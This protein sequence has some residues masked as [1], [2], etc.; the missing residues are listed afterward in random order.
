MTTESPLSGTLSSQEMYISAAQSVPLK[1]I[2][3]PRGWFAVNWRELWAYRELLYFLTW[4]DIKVR[5]KQ[6]ALGVIW[7]LLQPF[8][9][10]IVFSVIFG[11]L[12]K[13]DSEGFPY[14]VFLYAGLLPWQ[15]FSEALSQSSGSVVG[16]SGL[17]TKV[18]F[19]RLIVPIASVGGCLV[20]FAIS[21]LVV[22]GLMFYYHVSPTLH[23][24]MVF[25][26]VFVTMFA[27]LGAGTVLS[28]FSVAYRDFRYV[29]PFM[30]QIWMFVTPV[31]YP[32]KFVPPRWQ[33]ILKLNPMTGVV[34]GYRSALL[35]KPF[36]WSNLCVSLAVTAIVF[37]FGLFYFRKQEVIFA[38]IV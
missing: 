38:D 8:T 15:F 2:T 25:P 10:L 32:V 5:Y 21:F 14:P 28:A 1:I 34:D 35:G 6:T 19:P 30:L 20:D 7:A 36:E 22:L 13:I 3:P 31:I 11:R 9:K 24:L 37:I 18:Y 26:L 17:I 23:L 33:W 29:I 4:R 16:S 27:A 12:A